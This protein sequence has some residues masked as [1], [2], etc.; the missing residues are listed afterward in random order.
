V[1]YLGVNDAA[2]LVSNGGV[3]LT[4]SGVSYSLAAVQQGGYTFWGYEHLM[5]KASLSGTPLSF[6]TSLRNQLLS[7]DG[8]PL[9]S[10][11]NVVR[12]SDGGVVTAD[13]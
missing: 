5:Y 6:A 12:G 4:Y 13:Y 1:G 2:K 8:S 7:T 10:S 11:M 9:L 3:T